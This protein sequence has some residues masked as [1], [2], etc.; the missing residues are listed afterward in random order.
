[1]CYT[2][3]LD[4]MNTIQC[5]AIAPILPPELI[6]KIIDNLSA[7]PGTLKKCAIVCRSWCPRSRVHLFRHIRLH[8]RRFN[9]PEELY[10]FLCNNPY[11]CQGVITLDLDLL[12]YKIMV[13]PYEG[14]G[15][16]LVERFA[17]ILPSLQEL[18]IFGIPLPHIGL[19]RLEEV[20]L[21]SDSSD[22]SDEDDVE[23]EFYADY[24]QNTVQA[25]ETVS[26]M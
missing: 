17:G 13:G 23:G 11:I 5:Q 9:D 10:T 6:D 26:I 15:G 20:E 18:E 8:V 25:T 12:T 7:D 4:T 16:Y 2:I 3:C 14:D 1:M 19:P 22:S 24:V 21:D